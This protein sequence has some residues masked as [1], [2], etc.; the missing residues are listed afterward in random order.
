MG[1]S[2]NLNESMNRQWLPRDALLLNPAGV[3]IF[4]IMKS[5]RNSHCQQI[6]QIFQWVFRG[7]HLHIFSIVTRVYL[8]CDI[9][10]FE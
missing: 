3:D 10:L 1:L 2:R 9:S 6:L 5:L 7:E 8:L 4:G